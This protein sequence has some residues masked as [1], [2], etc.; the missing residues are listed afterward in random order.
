MVYT[1]VN[2]KD[3][4][5]RTFKYVVGYDPSDNSSEIDNIE[6]KI[7]NNLG[8]SMKAVYVFDRNTRLVREGDYW[9][10]RQKTTNVKQFPT[11]ILYKTSKLYIYF[12]RF[13]VET[14]NNKD[15]KY[16][17]N[18]NTWVNGKWVILGSYLIS[19]LDALA[20]PVKKLFGDEYVEYMVLD[21]I[22]LYDFIYG[23]GWK[24]F[25]EK[26]CGSS[27]VSESMLNVS[28]Y[29]VVDG[30][31]DGEYLMMDGYQGSQNSITPSSHDMNFL[32]AR[33]SYCDAEKGKCIKCDIFDNSSESNPRDIQWVKNYIT[34]D[35][36][37]EIS[38]DLSVRYDFAVRNSDDIYS[39]Q[40]KT[41]HSGTVS[42]AF[43]D[44]I[45]V[46]KNPYGWASKNDM[47]KAFLIDGGV[48]FDLIKSD[49]LTI[50]DLTIEYFRNLIKGSTDPIKTSHDGLHNYGL[51]RYLVGAVA[52][53][54]YSNTSKWGWL[55]KYVKSVYEG[56]SYTYSAHYGVGAF[57][58]SGQSGTWPVGPSFAEAGKDENYLP[59][60]GH[61]YGSSSMPM[62]NL[63]WD[64]WREYQETV[65]KPLVLQCIMTFLDGDKELF[66]IKSND[67]PFTQDT[68]GYFMLSYDRKINLSD[69]DMNLLNVNV[70]Q[71]TVQ[72]VYKYDNV[73]DAKSNIVQPVFFKA[74]DVENIIVHPE[75]TENICIN[76]D[77]FK[78]KVNRFLIQI[79]GCVFQEIGR[80]GSGVIFKITGNSLPKSQTSGLYYILDENSVLVT[81]GKY[82]YAV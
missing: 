6:Y 32:N 4:N 3:N 71:K 58:I 24:T 42:P 44:S 17:L 68:L 48:N 19:R 80:T 62:H 70:V 53:K 40:S 55:E 50:D 81:N 69:I 10:D 54:A 28:L 12:P 64:W 74:R 33:I 49:G 27:N 43:F 77:Q 57:F 56:S 78:S 15:V 72:T 25:K 47:L 1:S 11:K 46:D 29:P 38:G 45:G 66:Y 31:V 20:M 13:S 73:N 63:D 16:A 39:F 2:I 36:G 21:V 22:D 30:A 52:T 67:I 60:W 75:V 26:V 14:Y 61:K 79:E 5:N 18:I 51:C 9:V 41:L 35:L 76:L 23:N 34:N 7:N 8:N 37:V 82:K 59:V 65:G